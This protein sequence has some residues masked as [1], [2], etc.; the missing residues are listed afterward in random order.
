MKNLRHGN[1]I[2]LLEVFMT[3]YN[4]KLK[5]VLITIITAMVIVYVFPSPNDSKFKMISTT[6]SIYPAQLAADG[7]TNDDYIRSMCKNLQN[8][9]K[10]G[11]S[12]PCFLILSASLDLK[13]S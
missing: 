12:C 10:D 8:D 2:N 11:G 6:K 1:D 13:K 4:N 5:V 3:I 7:F 9:S